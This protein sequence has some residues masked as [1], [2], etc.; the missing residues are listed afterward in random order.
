MVENRLRL[1]IE[2]NFDDDGAFEEY[3]SD[4]GD[5]KYKLPL[6]GVIAVEINEAALPRLLEANAPRLVYSNSVITTQESAQIFT[7]KGIG[8][9]IIDT[10]VAP[11]CDLVQPQ[12]RIAAFVDFVNSKTEPYDDN[13]HGTHVSAIS[14]GNG[15]RSAGKRRGIAYE[16]NITAIKVLDENG[17]GDTADVL[18]GIEWMIANKKKYNIRVANL[19][20]G[21]NVANN[22]SVL[23][24]NASACGINTNG[25]DLLVK[26]VDAAWDAGIVVCV[27]AGN[28]GPAKNSVTSPGISRKVI[29]VG[30][31]DDDSAIGMKPNFSGRGPTADCIIKPDCLAPGAE[32]V[33]CLSNSTELS[34]EK[35]ASLK[36]ICKFYVKMSGTSMASPYVAGAIA[37][38]LEKE[39][40]LTPDEVKLRVKAACRKTNEPQHKQGWGILDITKLIKD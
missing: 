9:A 13:A 17:K 22:V 7:G 21:V 20:I 18:A 4:L 24:G 34:S 28:N 16:S 25:A 39:P 12:N 8:I 30:A 3:L 19:S 26:A 40:H 33:S 32:I 38:L 2:H 10:G 35:L 11:V 37:L 23:N 1:L 14:A 6:I 15:F 29:T 31:C 36:T 5:V 27:A